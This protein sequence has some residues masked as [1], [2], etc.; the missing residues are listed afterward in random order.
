MT[1]SGSETLKS[2]LSFSVAEYKRVSFGSDAAVED[3]QLRK[4]Q[5]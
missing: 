3:F 5:L 2:I 1:A 4:R